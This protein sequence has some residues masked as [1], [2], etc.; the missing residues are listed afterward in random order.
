MRL[1]VILYWR[2]LNYDTLWEA[3]RVDEQLNTTWDDQTDSKVA[4]DEDT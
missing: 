2:Q 1:F 4:D 3:E